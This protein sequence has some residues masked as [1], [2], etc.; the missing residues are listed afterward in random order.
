MDDPIYLAVGLLVI[1][2]VIGGVVVAH[3]LQK[4]GFLGGH[5][6]QGT[7]QFLEGGLGFRPGW[8]WALVVGLAEAVGGALMVIGFLGPIGPLAVAADLFVAMVAVH[9]AKGFWNMAGG[10]EFTLALVGA[11][12]GLALTGFGAV[13]VD[14]LIGLTYSEWVLVGWA[15]AMAIGAAVALVGGSTTSGAA[16]A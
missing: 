3:G 6:Q 1:R 5:G 11:S 9:W 12:I 2:V 4:F 15:A 14:A 8:F 7:I 10:I 13:S 16:K